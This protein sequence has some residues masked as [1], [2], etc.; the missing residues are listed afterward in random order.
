MRL[1]SMVS[2][3]G[4]QKRITTAFRG[5]NFSENF[6]EGDM[7]DSY[8]ISTEEY[9]TLTQRRGRENLPQYD[10]ATDIYEWD[11]KLL[12]VKEGKLLYDG[13]PLCN[14][15]D[16]E[17]Q[18]AVVN[19]KL[20]VWPDKLMV[21]LTNKSVEQMDAQITNAAEASSTA[22]S[23]TLS[24]KDLLYSSGTQ[25]YQNTKNTNLPW[26]WTYSNVSWSEEG[27]WV[28]EDPQ[29]T[30]LNG[31]L[32]NRYYIPSVEL[33]E[34]TG[35]YVMD[36]P[37]TSKWQK[38]APSAAE[39]PEPAPGNNIG[40]YGKFTGYEGELTGA[41]YSG[42][43]VKW[44][45]D[46][47]W[48][49]YANQN[50]ADIFSVGDNI[51]IEGTPGGLQDAKSVKILGID[52][53]TSTI[54]FAEGT[55]LAPIN[56]RVLT[57]DIV[58]ENLSYGKVYFG[59]NANSLYRFQIS[60][61]DVIKKGD[62]LYFYGTTDN[63]HVGIYDPNAM[64]TKYTYGVA[65]V[66]NASTYLKT[67]TYSLTGVGF[68]IKRIV[69]DLDYICESNNRLWGVINKQNNRIYDA[70]TGEYKEYTSRV[71]CA[72]ALGLPGRFYEFSGVDTDSYQVAVA[73]EGDFTG[74][75]SF[76]GVCCWKEKKLYKILGDYPSNY[77]M[78]EYDVAGV[79]KGSSRSVQ[80]MNETIYYKGVHGV[81]AYQGGVPSL[82]SSEFGTRR[83]TDGIA[84]NNGL[85]YY[86][87]V[88]DE[89]KK[90]VLFVY[91]LLNGFW[92]KEDNIRA[93]AFA[94]IG[95]SMY[96][97]T[98]GAVYLTGTADKVGFN[99]MAEFTPLDETDYVGTIAKK[100]YT[101]LIIRYDMAKGSRIRIEV[102]EDVGQWKTVYTQGAK[103]ELTQVV[104]V[105]LGRCDR[106]AIRISGHGEVKIR[107][108]VREF[109]VGSEV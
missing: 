82:I 99:W 45:V 92:V 54:S 46:F 74:I 48:A 18:F 28:L 10:G 53:D 91:N 106:C 77:Y 103:K 69:P 65:E 63:Y 20:I 72:S 39:F 56:Y 104:P 47:Y 9:P 67:T 26:A 93:D 81:Y 30:S 38:Y 62:V 24:T 15:I 76:G 5:I 34:S 64:K 60:P 1:P 71:I 66:S 8:G 97:L 59:N 32:R 94:S 108:I 85:G 84:G 12:V 101:K 78:N 42:I 25:S 100:G 43:K 40:F 11:G 6:R 58:Y 13:E 88:L 41:D 52:R 83:F 49:A 57:S 14:V 61:G 23:I 70:D 102:R 33:S 79:E 27:G 95:N 29:I 2:N 107:D 55:I 90:P 89:E 44:Y 73:S 86:L 87:S 98:D 105:R 36:W 75:C 17:K 4:K 7:R 109:R 37:I 3:V 31:G 80:I 22:G 96:M 51:D 50:V 21:D 16:G 35:K 19:T 68:T